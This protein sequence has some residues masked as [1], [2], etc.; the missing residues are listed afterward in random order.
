MFQKPSTIPSNLEVF[1]LPDLAQVLKDIIKQFD[2]QVK[3]EL[4]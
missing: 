1:Q 4:I 3:G 2:D